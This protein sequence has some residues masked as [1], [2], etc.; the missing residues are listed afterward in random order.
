MFHEPE[1]LHVMRELVWLLAGPGT[2]SMPRPPLVIV[3][4]EAMHRRSRYHD[5]SMKTDS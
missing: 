5:A 4:S 2:R 1:E 3:S